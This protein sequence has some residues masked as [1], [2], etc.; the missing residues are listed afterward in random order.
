M[1]D[2]TRELMHYATG[3]QVRGHKY[4]DRIKT[5]AGRWRYIYEKKKSG[6][7]FTEVYSPDNK[8][9]TLGIPWT[10]VSDN[11]KRM[12]DDL[13]DYGGKDWRKRTKKRCISFSQRRISL[14]WL[15][16]L[17]TRLMGNNL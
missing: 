3:T 5:R 14:A 17:M 16:T 11:T 2:Y 12:E 9:S 13:N 6:S 4:I 1:N 8:E 7:K 15:G 10:E